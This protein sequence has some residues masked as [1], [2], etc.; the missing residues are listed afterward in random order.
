MKTL[1]RAFLPL[2]PLNPPYTGTFRQKEVRGSIVWTRAGQFAWMDLDY[3][4]HSF[5]TSLYSRPAFLSLSDLTL[6][7]HPPVS[8]CFFFPIETNNVHRDLRPNEP[9]LF[10]VLLFSRWIPP[11]GY[12]SLSILWRASPCR[13]HS[14][15]TWAQ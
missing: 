8:T 12:H 6:L 9:F 15:L 10:S 7:S 4:A 5:L 14:N 2:Y 11:I 3:S 13:V 1:T